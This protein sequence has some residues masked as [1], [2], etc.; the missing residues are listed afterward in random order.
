MYAPNDPLAPLKTAFNT[1]QRTTNEAA[2]DV[3]MARSWL[4]YE[5]ADGE[6]AEMMADSLVKAE[7]NAR[8]ALVAINHIRE[9][10][11]PKK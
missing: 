9:L 10:T 1:A 4:G 8:A 11:K 2:S 6:A 7:E 5:D 3:A